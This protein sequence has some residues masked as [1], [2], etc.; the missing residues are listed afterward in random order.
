MT[1]TAP[2]TAMQMKDIILQRRRDGMHSKGLN[3]KYIEGVP[4]VL[5]V[6]ALGSRLSTKTLTSQRPASPGALRLSTR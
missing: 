5:L 2:S 1:T 3:N 4:I 6:L